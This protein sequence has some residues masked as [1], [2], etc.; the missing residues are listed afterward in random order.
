M[1]VVPVTKLCK[2]GGGAKSPYRSSTS[3]AATCVVTNVS[4]D[5]HDQPSSCNVYSAPR[6]IAIPSVCAF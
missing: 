5:R 4:G 6:Y 3:A 1:V 2:L